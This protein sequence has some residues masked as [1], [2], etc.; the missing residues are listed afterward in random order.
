MDRATILVQETVHTSEVQDLS[1]ASK[2]R[3]CCSRLEFN[4]LLDVG[5]FDSSSFGGGKMPGEFGG[6]AGNV[7]GCWGV[8]LEYT[9]VSWGRRVVSD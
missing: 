9:V 3:Y 5:S 2:H 7:A 8:V 6:R 4:C 1:G